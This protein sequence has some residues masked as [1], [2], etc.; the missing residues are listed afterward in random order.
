MMCR[1]EG[2]HHSA[3]TSLKNLG[4]SWTDHGIC[5][6]CGIEFFPQAG[7]NISQVC[8]KKIKSELILL[9]TVERQSKPMDRYK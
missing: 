1:I 9:Q 5:T 4:Y 8:R 3:K 6:C 7:Y 2:C